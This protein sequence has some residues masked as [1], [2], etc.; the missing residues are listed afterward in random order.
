MDEKLKKLAEQNRSRSMNA[1][2]REEQRIGFAYGN[3]PKNDKNTIETIREISN[4]QRGLT[5]TKK[6]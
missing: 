3:A 1:T 2:Q 4:A 6:A 5:E